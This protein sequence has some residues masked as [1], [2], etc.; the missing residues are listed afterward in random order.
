L[1]WS[2]CS[3]KPRA[4]VRSSAISAVAVASTTFLF[5]PA[6]LSAGLCWSAA[7]K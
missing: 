6:W 5:A 2:A 7:L 1:S 4:M 3:R